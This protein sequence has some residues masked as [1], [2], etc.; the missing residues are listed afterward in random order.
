MKEVFDWIYSIVIA[1]FLAMVIH[2]FLFVPTRVSG[3][4]MMPTLTNGEYLI[5]SKISHVLRSD[6]DY[7]N[8][9]IIDSP[10]QLPRP[11][12]DDLAQPL[13]LYQALLYKHPQVHNT[14]VNRVTGKGADVLEFKNGHGY[15]NGEELQEPYMNEPME[16]TME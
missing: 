5:V 6:P 16:F 12:M 15:R 1:L 13:S 11:W 9:V 2:I 3:E 14:W 7:G 4:S 8:I 10:V